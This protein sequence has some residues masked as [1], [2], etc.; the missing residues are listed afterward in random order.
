MESRREI[1]RDVKN[2]IIKLHREENSLGAIAKIV[3]RSRAT[4][5]TIVKNY[6]TR[7]NVENL[8]RSGRPRILSAR[9]SRS[10]IKNIKKNPR[11]SA[12]KLTEDLL[13]ET[14]KTVNPETVRRVLRNHGYNG[15]NPRRK[16]DEKA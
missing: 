15:R 10:I 14:G 6:K 16:Q 2:I 9:D 13:R 3:G 12:P 4:V 8:R 11:L 5:Q 7:G 1:S